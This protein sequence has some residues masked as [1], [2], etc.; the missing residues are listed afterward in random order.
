MVGCLVTNRLPPKQTRWDRGRHS[1]D[2]DVILRRVVKP[3]HGGV[4]VFHAR[5]LNC[6]SER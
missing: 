3:A 5:C 1:A 4:Q 2:F 6:N